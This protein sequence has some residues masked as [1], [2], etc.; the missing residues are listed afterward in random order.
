VHDPFKTLKSILHPRY[1][2]EGPPAYIERFLDSIDSTNEPMKSVLDLIVLGYRPVTTL[3]ILTTLV[4][5]GNR[6]Q[7]GRQLGVLLEKRFGLEEGKLTKGRYYDDRISRLLKILCQLSILELTETTSESRVKKKEGYRIKEPIYPTI[8]KVIRSFLNGGSL[9]PLSERVLILDAGDTQEFTV[10]HCSKC[11]SM[12]TSPKATH[13]ELCGH[14]L[15]IVCKKCQNKV[16]SKWNF[17]NSCGEPLHGDNNNTPG[18]NREIF[19]L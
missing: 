13:C 8:E 3:C 1:R 14:P 5:S 2:E 12:T 18:E 17:C 19:P 4:E 7:T 6:P 9:S 11:K 16:L 10:K 15:T